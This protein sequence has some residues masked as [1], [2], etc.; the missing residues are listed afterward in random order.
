MTYIFSFLEYS[1]IF[2]DKKGKH[3]HEGM[4]NDELI[5]GYGANEFATGVLTIHMD[6][7]TAYTNLNELKTVLKCQQYLRWRCF[8]SGIW[9]NYNSAVIQTYFKR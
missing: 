7:G 8:K 3:S 4:V 5:E 1:T 2:E 6:H 9:K